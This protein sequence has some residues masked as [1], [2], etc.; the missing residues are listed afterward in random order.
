[1]KATR[2]PEVKCI[3]GHSPWA[4]TANSCAGMSIHD[5]VVT[6]CECKTPTIVNPLFAKPI[7]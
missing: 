1:M 4:H 6:S 5:G 2:K 3:C 7:D